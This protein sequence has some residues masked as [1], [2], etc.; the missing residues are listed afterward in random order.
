MV[1]K[2]SATGNTPPPEIQEK[3]EEISP[4]YKEVRN[5]IEVLNQQLGEAVF[6]AFGN[7]LAPDAGIY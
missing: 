1:E 7:D 5:T 4:K 6:A 3:F 2:C